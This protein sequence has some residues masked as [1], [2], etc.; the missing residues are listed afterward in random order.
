MREY[1]NVLGPSCRDI[2]LGLV[3]TPDGPVF[4]LNKLHLDL[5]MA[6]EIRGRWLNQ[7]AIDVCA[8][9]VRIHTLI[10]HVKIQTRGDP[11]LLEETIVAERDRLIPIASSSVNCDPQS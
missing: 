5:G 10:D 9:L 3:V 7:N 2:L 11:G 1:G 4:E 8:F 6:D